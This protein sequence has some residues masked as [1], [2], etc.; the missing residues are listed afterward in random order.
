[1]C[2]AVLEV[3]RT[4]IDLVAGAGSVGGLLV[5]GVR[6]RGPFQ[7]TVPVVTIVGKISLNGLHKFAKLL[8]RDPRRHLAPTL[9]VDADAQHRFGL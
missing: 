4:P 5:E 2:Q 3:D 7:I 1:M 6:H 9:H 8:E